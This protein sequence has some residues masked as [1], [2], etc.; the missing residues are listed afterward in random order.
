[1]ETPFGFLPSSR[2]VDRQAADKTLLDT[3]FNLLSL[4][5]VDL[6]NQSCVLGFN[7]A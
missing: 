7:R 5:V 6:L 3:G 4:E 1:M 2:E